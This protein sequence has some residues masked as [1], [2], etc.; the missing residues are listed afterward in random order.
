MRLQLALHTYAHTHKHTHTYAN[1]TNQANA[2]L[3]G[4]VVAFRAMR[5]QLA[6]YTHTH[7]DTHTHTHNTHLHTQTHTH[8]YTS[9]QD[10]INQVDAVL[11]GFVLAFRAM[12]QQLALQTLFDVM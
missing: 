1:Q 10:Q 3:V 11:F 12:C 8:V 9:N 6:L 7:P 2:V 5:R 4:F